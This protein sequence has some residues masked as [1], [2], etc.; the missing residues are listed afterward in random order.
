MAVV[1]ETV[2]MYRGKAPQLPLARLF[3]V[4]SF[5]LG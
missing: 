2:R 4:T 1:F 3:G 5:E